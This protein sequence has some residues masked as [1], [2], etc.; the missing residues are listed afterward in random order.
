MKTLLIILSLMLSGFASLRAEETR[1]TVLQ[2]SGKVRFVAPGGSATDLKAGSMLVQ[3]TRLATGEAAVAVLMLADGSRLTVGPNTELT[4]SELTKSDSGFGNVFKLIKGFL[5]ATVQKL[6]TGSKFE[7]HGANAVAAVK[8]TEY[9]AEVKDDGLEVRVDEG[10]VWLSD[11]K[12]ERVEEVAAGRAARFIRNAIEKSRDLSSD[13]AAEMKQRREALENYLRGQAGQGNLGAQAILVAAWAKD[14]LPQHQHEYSLWDRLRPEQKV[15]LLL[16]LRESMGDTWDDITLLKHEQRQAKWRDRLRSADERRLAAEE[17]HID[18]MRGKSML[19][20]KGRR[21]RFDEFLMRDPAQPHKMQFLNY[22]RR[23]GRTDLINVVNTYN[24]ALPRSLAD[25]RGMNQKVW[26]SAPS[27]WVVQSMVAFANGDN[28]F[29]GETAFFDPVKPLLVNIWE[30]PIKSIELRL[31]MDNINLLQMPNLAAGNGTLLERYDRATDGTGNLVTAAAN[32]I[33]FSQAKTSNLIWNGGIGFVGY[34]DPSN[35]APVN[36]D[37]NSVALGGLAGDLA[38]GFKRTYADGTWIG[39]STYAIDE[40][41]RVRNWAEFADRPLF[42][43]LL[44]LAFRSYQEIEI[45]SSAFTGSG[46]IDVVSQ[47]LWWYT[48]TKRADTL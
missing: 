9:E 44:D 48:I 42:D 18:F 27:Y 22:S 29:A 45:T 19:D 21:V 23:E 41:G 37:L 25:A 34:L 46:D 36:Q 16:A 10:K 47:M 2:V 4:L 43:A 17:A 14:S 31:N 11:L 35:V 30:L 6:A 3:G 15:K 8:G 7:V 1:A 26:I 13:E 20:R 40:N 38:G 24:Q 32:A 28:N 33:S 5:R 12:R 39:M